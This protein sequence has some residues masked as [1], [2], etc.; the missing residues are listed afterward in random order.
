MSG[1]LIDVL[2]E[3]QFKAL[4][5]IDIRIKIVYHR[6]QPSIG[7]RDQKIIQEG[8]AHTPGDTSA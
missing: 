2:L 4:K 7:R 1:K 6:K 8:L 5:K 3:F